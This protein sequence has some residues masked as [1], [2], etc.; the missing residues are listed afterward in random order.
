MNHPT[1]AKESNTIATEGEQSLNFKMVVMALRLSLI[2]WTL[3]WMMAE[4]L[5]KISAGMMAGIGMSEE[6]EM[7]VHFTA[8]ISTLVLAAVVGSDER[9]SKYP[10]YILRI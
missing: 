7:I 10:N 4:T 3:K 9:L 8:M 2:E 1:T 6:E 5:G